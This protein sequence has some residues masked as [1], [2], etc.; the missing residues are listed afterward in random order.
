MKENEGSTVRHRTVPD[1]LVSVVTWKTPQP[2]S[3]ASI[4]LVASQPPSWDQLKVNQSKQRKLRLP[5]MY[6]LTRSQIKPRPLLLQDQGHPKKNQGQGPPFVV[7]VGQNKA[8][9]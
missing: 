4:S 2:V 3:R 7:V 1:L 6:S 8:V 9:Q 5:T